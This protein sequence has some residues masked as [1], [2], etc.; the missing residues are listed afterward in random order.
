MSSAKMETVF[1]Y[2]PAAVNQGFKLEAGEIPILPDDTPPIGMFAWDY[3]RSAADAQRDVFGVSSSLKNVSATY[4]FNNDHQT[5][6]GSYRIYP[7]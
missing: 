1:C 7:T 4:L 5:T 6:E 2:P 3:Y